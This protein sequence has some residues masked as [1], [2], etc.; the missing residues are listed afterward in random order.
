MTTSKIQNSNSS[1]IENWK[2]NGDIVAAE[3]ID[4]VNVILMEAARRSGVSPAEIAD[5]MSVS[6]SRVSQIVGEP[7]NL[8][9]STIA[10]FL[11][12]LRIAPCFY[13]A[14]PSDGT[15]IDGRRSVQT[16]EVE[17]KPRKEAHVFLEQISGDDSSD[18]RPLRRIIVQDSP[19]TTKVDP[20]NWVATHGWDLTARQTDKPKGS[21]VYF[22]IG[23][24]VGA[25]Q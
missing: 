18:G 21:T 9:L 16:R 5:R 25:W 24:E 11:S 10:R 14:D 3:L 15:V 2:D 8:R 22:A 7:S 6:P 4:H 17:G 23:G 19:V 12:A 1:P 20:K 13:G